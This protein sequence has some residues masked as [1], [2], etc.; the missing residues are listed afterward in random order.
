MLAR[1]IFTEEHDLYR[2]AAREFFANEVAPFHEQWEKDGVV[3]RELWEKAGAQGHSVSRRARGI[4]RC[5]RCR[6]PL[7]GDPD[8]GAGRGGRR[9]ARVRRPQRH[10]GAVPH[11]AGHRGAEAAL[12]ARHGG[13]DHDRRHCDDRARHRQR[14][15]GDQDQ[16][17]ARRRPLHRERGQDV[18]HQRA[19]RRPGDRGRPYFGRS[20]P[21]PFA[22]GGRAGDGRVRAG[23]QPRQARDEGPGHLGAVLRRRAGAGGQSARR[24]GGGLLL[25]RRPTCPR[26]GW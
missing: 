21:G 19:T 13:G 11:R 6:L 25:P 23:P 5:R 7:P 16:G 22:A 18:H 8:R 9:R 2:Q 17:R 12:A 24:G 20:A 4:R 14:P 10:R 26:S 1:T 3:P 15:V